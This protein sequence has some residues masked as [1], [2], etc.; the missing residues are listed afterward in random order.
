MHYQRPILLF[1]ATFSILV[2]VCCGGEP[3][4]VSG[5][6]AQGQRYTVPV[7]KILLLDCI[8]FNTYSGNNGTVTVG[9]GVITFVAGGTANTIPFPRPLKLL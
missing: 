1:A 2:S 9:A 3:V 6:V 4:P 5:T 8:S 7:G